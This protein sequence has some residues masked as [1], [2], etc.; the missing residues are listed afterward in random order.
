MITDDIDGYNYIP[1]FIYDGIQ[2]FMPENGIKV[3]TRIV[4]HF[5]SSNSIYIILPDYGHPCPQYCRSG[6][7]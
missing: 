3:D 6:A 4:K 5:K 7:A 1:F 2:I